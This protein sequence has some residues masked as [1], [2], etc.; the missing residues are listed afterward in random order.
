MKTNFEIRDSYDEALDLVAKCFNPMY[1]LN[2]DDNKYWIV[3][4]PRASKLLKQGYIIANKETKALEIIQK[5]PEKYEL[6]NVSKNSH[7]I[8]KILREYGDEQEAVNDL[9]RL[10]AGE[11]TEQELA[12]GQN[13]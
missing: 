4:L 10:L 13:S 6:Q 12:D 3:N 9:T 8:V 5:S 2:G 1:I 7:R 11:I